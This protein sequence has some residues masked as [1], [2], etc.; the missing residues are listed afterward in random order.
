MR[1]FIA[2]RRTN[3]GSL[4][5]AL[6]G[7]AAT[8]AI[9]STAMAG[10]R[11]EK[12]VRGD[13][14]FTR[15]G[16]MTLI[17]ASNNSIIN[18]SSFDILSHE[19]VQFMQPGSN[20]RVLNRIQSQLPTTIDGSLMA[21]GIVYL[22]NPAGVIF[23]QGAV[24]DTAGLFAAAGNI[25]DDDFLSNI[26]HF[27]DLSGSVINHGVITS[28]VTHLIGQQV[29]NHGIIETTSGMVSLVAGEDVIITEQG[30]PIHVRIDGGATQLQE[31]I[32]VENT[33]T[34]SNIGGSV[35]LGAGDVYSLAIKNSGT[36]KADRIVA[37]AAQGAGNV[38]HIEG[39]LDAS[40]Y[41]ERGKGGVV[42]ILG[43]KVALYDATIDASGTRG[44]GEILV[45]GDFQGKGDVQNAKRNYVSGDAWLQADA[46]LKGKGG[47]IIVWSDE[48]TSF[49]GHVQARGGELRGRGGFAEVSG[50][51]YLAF[52]GSADLYSVKKSKT[53][54]LLLD[55]LNITIVDGNGNVGDGDNSE[56]TDSAILFGER[57]GDTV[58]FGEAFI[59]QTSVNV[60]LQAEQDITINDLS[61]D[62]LDFVNLTTGNS[63][64]FQAGRNITFNDTNDVI[65]TN[66]ADLHLEANSFHS[67]NFNFTGTLTLGGINTGGGDVTLFGNN[68]LVNTA[69]TTG[70]G[71]IVI[72]AG[73]DNIPIAL[74]D[75]GAVVLVDAEFDL[76]DPGAGT[77][78][79]GE[80]TTAG[81]NGAFTTNQQTFTANSF[82]V[83]DLTLD[84]KNFTLITDA[85]I[86]DTDAVGAAITTTG[87][88]TLD[89]G[90]T[91]GD[92]T[93][94]GF[95]F[96]A[97][98]LSVN[99][100]G[101]QVRFTDVGA[102]DTAIVFGRTGQVV[103]FDKA[104]GN[105]DITDWLAGGS[106]NIDVTG[107]DITL[108]DTG[109][110]AGAIDLNAGG[111]INA[112][113]GVADTAEIIASG[114]VTLTSATGIGGAGGSLE[115]D[116]QG[117]TVDI[118]VTGVG[119]ATVRNLTTSLHGV[120][121]S[122]TGTGNF[123]YTGAGNLNVDGITS[124]GGD[125]SVSSV[126]GSVQVQAQI[127]TSGGNGNINLTNE[128]TGDDL[129]LADVADLLNAGSGDVTIDVAGGVI[130]SLSGT[131]SDITTT[132]TANI[133]AR[134]TG[135]TLS[136]ALDVN[137][138]NL[139][140]VDRSGGA[141]NIAISETAESI[142]STTITQQDVNIGDIDIAYFDGDA[143]AIDGNATDHVFAASSLSDGDFTFIG[144]GGAFS[145]TGAINFAGSGD[146][147][148]TA[149]AGE[150]ITFDDATNV[151][152]DLTATGGAMDIASGGALGID[153]ITSDSTVNLESTGGITINA[154]GTVTANGATT[155]NS[156]TD[157]D[158]G[159]FTISAGG[160]V[161]STD[162]TI[163]ITASDLVLGG[164]VD[165]GTAAVSITSS[166]DGTI[167][168]GNTAGGMTIDG[169]DLSNITGSELTINTAG[170]MTV[171]GIN[172]GADLANIAGPVTLNATGA[173]SSV[174]FA[175]GASTFGDLNVNAGEGINVDI[176]LT[177]DALTLDSDSDTS[178][179]GDVD[180]NAAVVANT[181]F[182]SSGFDFDNTGGTIDGGG[183]A[184]T[185][186]HTGTSTIGGAITN[187]GTT[188]I[189]STN[190]INLAAAITTVDS[191]LNLN[192][193]VTMTGDS[194]LSTGAGGGN[195][196]FGST[197]DGAGNLAANAGTGNVDASAGAIGGTTA[198]TS[199][200]FDGD[201]ITLG[202]VTTT[203]AQDYT[204]TTGITLNSD[205]TSTTAGA[206]AF[207]GDVTLGSDA[208]VTTA[209]G[210]G[211]DITFTDTVDGAFAL[212]ANAGGAG[213]VDAQGDIGGTT[214]LTS[215]DFT[216]AMLDAANVSTTGDQDYAGAINLNGATYSSSTAGNITL[217]GAATLTTNSS[218]TTVGGDITFTSTV[219]G[220]FT[221]A[222]DAGAGNVDAQGD[223][224]GTTPLTSVDF[225]GAT[226]DVANV[227][228][229]GAQDYTGA[230]NLNGDTYSSTTAGTM[231]FDGAVTLG[232]NA[233]ITSAGGAGDDITFTNTVD[234]AFTLTANAGASGA[235]DAQ[236][237]IG[238]TT[239]LAGIDF[240]GD[241]ISVVDATTTGSQD[242]TGS[243]S[244]TLNGDYASTTAGLLAFNGPVTLAGDTTASTAGGG[245]DD[246]TFTDFV[247][248]GF[249]LSA[250][251]GAAGIVDAQSDIGATTELASILF[252]GA[253][254]NVSIANTS[255]A[256][257]YTATTINATGDLTSSTAGDITLDGNTNVLGDMTIMTAGAVGDDVVLTGTV[258]GGQAL[259]ANAGL[260][261]V[262][263]QGAIGGTTALTS[264][265]FT[266]GDINLTDV[267]T[268]G[269]QTYTGSGTINLAS[270]FTSTGPGAITYDGNVVLGSNTNVV[271]G[272]AAGDDITFNGT[273]DGGF[274]LVANAGAS[275][276]IVANGLI[277]DT[278]PLASIDFDGFDITVCG[279]TTTGLQDYTALGTLTLGGDFTRTTAGVFNFNG[280][281]VIK[282]DTTITTAGA[283]GDDVNFSS[284]VDGTTAGAESL[285]VNAGLGDIAASGAVGGTT[286]LGSVDFTG[287]NI[288]LLDVT[289]TG[290]QLYTA[291]GTNTINGTYSSTTAGSI[292]FAGA[293]S[294]GGDSTIMTAGG[295]GDDINLNGTVDGAQMLTANAGAA[296]NVNSTGAIGGTTALTA[297]DFDGAD[298]NLVDVTTTGN[299][300]YT[301][302][303][304]IGTNGTISNTTAGT[305]AFNG[306][307]GMAGDTTVNSA[308]AVGDDITFGGTV[309][310][311]FNLVANAGGG[312]VTGTGLIGGTTA[313]TSVDIDAENITV[314]GA[315]STGSQAYDGTTAVNIGGDFA[316]TGAGTIDFN[317]PTNLTAD[318][319]VTSAGAAGDD[320]G[321]SDTIDG[322]FALD[323]D[324]GAAGNVAFGGVVGGTTALSSLTVD[325]GD[326]TLADVTT[327]GDQTYDSSSTLSLANTFTST[328]SGT[329]TFN[330]DVLLAG[331]TTVDT[332]GTA[333]F[334]G[335]IDG[336]TAETE[337][338]TI[339][340][341]NTGA[342][343]LGGA[344]GQTTRLGTLTVADGD[345]VTFD[346]DVNAAGV[347]VT[348]NDVT[349]NGTIDTTAGGS[350]FT[351]ASTLDA[352][353]GSLTSTGD[354]M[355][356]G[357]G[358]VTLGSDVTAG[359]D[360]SFD[361]VVTLTG[362]D[363]NAGGDA[364]FND[365]ANLT[366]NVIAGNDA[367]FNGDATITGDV[368]TGN[369][370]TFAGDATLNG[371]VT[372]G[373]DATFNG[374][375]SLGG[376][377]T[378]GNDAAFNGAVT[379]AG[380]RTITGS[381]VAFNSTVDSD[382]TARSLSVNTSGGGTTT[383]GGDVGGS[384]ALSSLTTN[385]DGTTNL[386]AA[387]TTTNGTTINDALTLT[388][389]SSITDSGTNG[390][391]IG[392]VDGPFGLTMTSS[393]D[394]TVGDVGATT[395]LG[396]L[397]IQSGT[398]DNDTILF[399][400]TEVN[401]SGDIILNAAGRAAVPLVATI[402]ADGPL[403]IDSSAGDFTMGQNEKLT[404][405]GSLDILA[406]GTATL[407]DL[408]SGGAMNVNAGSITALLRDAGLITGSDGG[409]AQ[410][411]GLDFVSGGAM[412]FTYG[413]ATLN[414]TGPGPFFGN[415]NATVGGTGSFG[416]AAQSRTVRAS[417][418]TLG[419]QFLDLK[420][421]GPTSTN[422]ANVIAGAVPRESQSGNVGQDTSIGQAQKEVL[423]R[424]GIFARD[425]SRDELLDFLIGRAIYNDL[426]ESETFQGQN[427]VA[428]PRLSA[429]LVDRLVDLYDSTYFRSEIDPATGEEVRIARDAEL[430]GLF[431]DAYQAY[432]MR[433][434]AGTP[435]ATGFADFLRTDPSAGEALIVAESLAELMQVLNRIGLTP[436]EFEGA[437]YTLLSSITP[438]SMPS[439][440]M[441]ADAVGSIGGTGM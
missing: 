251:A 93:A 249:A 103:Q 203:G 293:T 231:T 233:T 435:T 288:G 131:N 426:P 91:I 122:H 28:H 317:G 370:A 175:T 52:T 281:L 22:V 377:V 382:G 66:G 84:A 145:Q 374:D 433:R 155:I 187:A 348:A 308:G 335:T 109:L 367:A 47:K 89:A 403:T 359:G 278:T 318:S 31:G 216:G 306:N 299:Q 425:A 410:D 399:T 416:A 405:T 169:T 214:A 41:S 88:L 73:R 311:A 274:D 132:G 200:D 72:S 332:G 128:Q 21:N 227:T 111:A 119:D 225:D 315:T 83:D 58:F 250:D 142:T 352:S 310:G 193:A 191:D 210:G 259:T 264:V 146:N 418:L 321:F 104:S 345:A 254:V 272:G 411:N 149:N 438:E 273:V 337:D 316:S 255:G 56:V 384:A 305:I 64:T 393:S 237:A 185:I 5:R 326:V 13:V 153:L 24:I 1:S 325:G 136:D 7:G 343:N 188:N 366:G 196:T 167:G 378:A 323:V 354:I 247:D 51:D 441:M 385:A 140:I 33:G 10:P 100:P 206:I 106:V 53:G 95:S 223:I 211:D 222:A 80:A 34:I 363:I 340:L 197:I 269:D 79:V 309:D 407:G 242:Y 295:A 291:S 70:G 179:S 138:A 361:G 78:I 99:T 290:D 355:Q 417:E 85:R 126:Q 421:E 408:T 18:Y 118:N 248:G 388:G 429:E 360:A 289:T 369:D 292:T 15:R 285:T 397:T 243:T 35:E 440:E 57:P 319:S 186:N 339:N 8:I 123:D 427:E 113:A 43:D 327:T 112:N 276:D 391:T 412:T 376:D 280:P 27:T 69:I 267:T 390:I 198:L 157:A 117:N 262:D 342:L 328:G 279:A 303:G 398:G 134:G 97:P 362:G 365:D 338:L 107:G 330:G 71:D 239:A 244:I 19:S 336:T 44:G 48:F 260:G 86:N 298:I 201:T 46:I 232:D 61:D 144:Q 180:I 253:T 54:T 331:N 372:A 183:N 389:T 199:V 422:V 209:G 263:A 381:N 368:T 230:I 20:A 256:Q 217:D 75:A 404:A 60:I 238:G 300:D 194:D 77:I 215:V 42:E 98:N 2:S 168:V 236:G 17:E 234:G 38:V 116:S 294:L 252:E 268:V 94:D 162:N 296:G 357:A 163:D 55:P 171:D 219:D 137:V 173:A 135:T 59:E 379:L 45:G 351:V 213:N 297:T 76:M 432:V 3:R 40:D 235:V 301:A 341:N 324:G 375:A 147:T 127:D 229:T 30:E 395:R 434:A 314:V 62:A 105:L 240:D 221:L 32:G 110:T 287:A 39:T 349:V 115:I 114:A 282:S 23:G 424:M 401:T 158:G 87:T 205:Y 161:D 65:I 4:G 220:A 350:T 192:S 184:V 304:T 189:T 152:G 90:G 261:T 154:G 68:F 333:A 245:G 437:Q 202:D 358:V 25:S 150:S 258:D 151:F 195:I 414:G 172:A 156:D 380:D 14:N 241:T 164:T 246:I 81:D 286:A 436:V 218:I 439:W 420:A 353:A 120:T 96:D 394:V 181:S 166:D 63:V 9:A 329:I 347:D 344:V 383:F 275:G 284:T 387:I 124:T 373:N 160:S 413:S 271:T 396:S 49:D 37:K 228:T 320:I 190:G 364:T 6:L 400:G 129:F 224:G 257:T 108:N 16:H 423:Q 226:I 178:G 207:N 277:G 92:L 312:D 386:G 204:G 130:N 392:T 371:V 177:A 50:K 430:K 346:V 307:V 141:E 102:G 165:A 125:V 270:T 313:V 36:I 302:S 121:G 265:D 29:G 143:I 101:N 431:S 406:S 74:D 148:F 26:N 356:V 428:V 139:V 266:G 176:G 419:N 208:T 11:G 67:S 182:D 170:N 409:A 12:V 402:G 283:V 212:T 159:A 174:T 82:T 133:F 322:A 334:N 415:P